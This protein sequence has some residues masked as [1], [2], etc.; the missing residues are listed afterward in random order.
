MSFLKKMFGSRPE[1][2]AT[3]SAPMTSASAPVSDGLAPPADPSKDPDMIRV[4][5]SYGREAF[6]SRQEWRDS[7]LMPHIRKVWNDPDA[8]YSVILQA[9]GDGFASDMASPAE[10]LAAVDPNPERG[11]VVLANVYREQGRLQESEQILLQ[12]LERHGESGIVLT[13]LAKVLPDGEGQLRTLWRALELDPNQEN[14]LGWYEAIHRE[15]GGKEEGL[16]ALRRIAALPGSWRARIWIAR[17]ALETGDVSGALVLYREV[18]EMAPRPLPA[19]LLMQMSGDLGRNGRLAEVLEF[20]EPHFELAVHGLQV[21]NNLIKAYVDLGRF[22]S[23]RELVQKLYALNR[24]D[25]KP[26]LSFWDNEIARVQMAAAPVAP[27]QK[28]SITLLD[29]EGPIWLPES[30]LTHELVPALQSEPVRVA[31]L[32]STAETGHMDTG[33]VQQLS[34]GPGRLSRAIPLFLA[35]QARLGAGVSAHV[36]QPWIVSPRRGFV[37]SGVPWTDEEA[38]GYARRHD[39]ACEYLVLTHL[40]TDREMWQA[41]LR[42]LRADDGTCLA[43]TRSEFPPGE[44]HAALTGLAKETLDFLLRSANAGNAAFPS[45]YQVPMGIGFVSYLVRLEQLL[46]VRCSGLDEESAGFFSGERDI[47]DGNLQLCLDQPTN[48]TVRILLLHTALSL[49]AIRPGIVA[50]YA[51]KLR[52][53]QREHP[54][55][56]PAG[57]AVARLMEGIE[58]P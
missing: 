22:D 39:L 24:P 2:Q 21:A 51:G 43:V 7:V 23:A 29:V 28:L 48:P 26:T 45:F 58:A 16:A 19:D 17:A 36:L 12:Y 13:N 15:Q 42:M 57:A 52:L 41:E 54:L 25:W 10:Q 5:D 18:L 11:A 34:D 38:S 56:G 53:L 9:L 37:L 20:T 31:F 6:V 55:S 44:P 40:R 30:S 46:A 32:G 8:L 14:G 4:F 47:L 27:G 50:E 3:P 1:S 35:E 49:K 33:P